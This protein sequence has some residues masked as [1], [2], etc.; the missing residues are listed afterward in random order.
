MALSIVS[1]DTNGTALPSYRTREGTSPSI[2]LPPS[3]ASVRSRV[4]EEASSTPYNQD[5]SSGQFLNNDDHTPR[6]KEE[7][8]G[9][10]NVGKRGKGSSPAKRKCRL[11][12][13]LSALGIVILIILIVVPVT[14]LKKNNDS[15]P[16]LGSSDG[17]D[18]GRVAVTGF[19]G[20]EV[21]LEDGS[22]MKYSNR[23]GGHW[24]YD[25]NN[26]FNNGAR[27][28]SWSPGLNETFRY[29]IDKIRGV[30]LGGWLVLEPFMQVALFV[31]LKLT[32]ILTI[33]QYHSCP[34]PFEK[35]QPEAVDE[36]TLHQ[37][38]AANGGV[39]QLEEHYKTFITEKDFAE[40]AGAGLNYIRLPIPYWAVET[41]SNEPFLPNVA[42]KYVLK[43][44]QWSRKYG[45]RINLDLHTVPGSQNDSNHSGRRGDVNFLRGPMGYANAQRTLDIIRVIAEFISQPQY[46]DV[47][48]MF[49][50]VNEPREV[51]IGKDSIASFYAQ[52]YKVI[53]EA[54][55]SGHGAWISFHDA[56]MSKAD[57]A[58][59]LSGGERIS[60]DSH[61][62]AAFGNNQ[63]DQSWD[64][65][66]STPCQWG[67][68]FNE[69]MGVFGLSSAGEWSNAINDCG[70]WLNGIPE[71][72]RY[73]GTYA[74]S[75]RVGSCDRWLDYDNY[76]DD[77]KALI[78]MFALASMDGLQNYF[79]L[80]WKIGASTKTNKVMSPAWSYQLGLENGWMPKDPRDADGTCG[81]V[82]PFTGTISEG[83]G[84][85]PDTAKYPWPPASI[86]MGGSPADLPRYTATGAIPTLSGATFT[87]S[88]VQPTRPWM[89]VTD[90]RTRTTRLSM[91][92]RSK[93][94]RTPIPGP[95]MLRFR[96]VGA[97]RRRRGASRLLDLWLPRRS[98]TLSRLMF[99]EDLGIYDEELSNRVGSVD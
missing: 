29:G 60:L 73:D 70:L 27:A 38:M 26:P 14:V 33:P 9:Y 47:V 54:S 99:I 67:R 88:G 87:V 85:N 22:T 49:G 21:T 81:N 4:S 10:N 96:S 84:G 93:D 36:Y 42:W 63:T 3:Y 82:A 34:A 19:D 71:G 40:I 39:E 59:F 23:H 56:M 89:L 65:H 80:T 52:A 75:S 8:L 13:G 16:R 11:T 41:H 12:I 66:I 90:G 1:G 44:I 62:Y 78:K 5:N 25:P 61:P 45:L 43:A 35:F 69:S 50:P 20:S 28:Q 30:N 6:P 72:T 64:A 97:Q 77:T 32:S 57:W 37:A 17:S 48:T 15:N 83:L 24:Y 31:L 92:L 55:G 7:A 18:G 79:F 58:G 95:T 74:G 2:S 91:W 68:E 94:A 98:K 53:R 51:Q 76:S 86:T 46:R